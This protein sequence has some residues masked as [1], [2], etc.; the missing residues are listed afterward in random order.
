MLSIHPLLSTDSVQIVSDSSN[1]IAEM[2]KS[3]NFE[4]IGDKLLT[5]AISFGGKLLLAVIIFLVGRFLIIQLNKITGKLLN[6]RLEDAALKSFL[7]SVLLTILYIILFVTIIQWVGAKTV[8]IAALIASAGLAIGLAVKDNLSNFAGGVMI[9]LNKPFKGGDYIEAQDLQ[10]TV[11]SIGIL[12]TVLKTFDNRTIFIPNGPLSTGNIINYDSRDGRR[13]AEIVVSVEYGSD[14]DEIKKILLD[15]A[16]EHPHVMKTPA[17]FAR[18][19]KMNDSSIDFSFRF[20]TSLDTY[21]NTLYD[22][23]EEIYKELTK[24]GLNIPFPQMTVH[25][26]KEKEE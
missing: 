8:S 2:I 10:G 14:I 9:L 1:G 19:T 17:P 25:L 7:Q 24:R 13:R 18:M 11:V 12:Y 16:Q 3:G 26:A 22:I 21:W 6:K 15:V 23:N 5:W 20:W 4:A